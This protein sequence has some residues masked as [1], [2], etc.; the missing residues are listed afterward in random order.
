MQ[1]YFKKYI[2]D[3]KGV[4]IGWTYIEFTDRWASRQIE[5]Y[6]DGREYFIDS[7]DDYFPDT[8]GFL[9]DQP[10]ENVVG[11]FG[12]D[13]PKRKFALTPEDEI[14]AAEFETIWNTQD[15][16]PRAMP[17]KKRER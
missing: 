12:T 16:N 1:R 10:I 11:P 15:N 2:N 4:G 7:P 13:D 9:G 6:A 5:V 14:S 17:K 3:P 8:G